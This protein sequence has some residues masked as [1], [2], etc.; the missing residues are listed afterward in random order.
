MERKQALSELLQ[1]IRI[2]ILDDDEQTGSSTR[3]RLMQ[4]DYPFV[5][6]TRDMGV[7]RQ[8]LEHTNILLIDHYLDNSE[9]N[10]IEFTREAKKKYGKNLD[11]IIYY[12]SVDKLAQ[13]AQ[14]AGATACLEKPLIFEYLLL[15]IE[16][17][18]KR[19]WLEKILDAIP[20]EVVVI[21]PSDEYFGR[22]HYVNK[23]KKEHFENNVPLEYDYCWRR[24]ERKGLGKEPCP[25]CI[26]RNAISSRRAVR[27]YR[28]YSTWDGK[29]EAVDIH[30]API[31]DQVGEIRGIIETCRLRTDREKVENKLKQIEAEPDWT[32]RLDLFLEGFVD[33]GYS[34]VRFYKCQKDSD[35][36]VGVKQLGMPKKF[37]IKNY[38]YS[39][40]EDMPTRITCS[41]KYPTLFL[42]KPNEGYK[43][44]PAR[45]YQHVY[46]VDDELVPNN[47]ILAKVKWVEIPVM[48]DG[49]IIAKVS[50]EPDLPD[51]FISNYELEILNDYSEWAGQALMNAEQSQRL[52][53]NDETKKLIIDMNRK[54]SRMSLRPAWMS[55]AVKRVCEVLD[56][57][58]CSIFLLEGEG[59]NQRLV[60]QTTYLCNIKGERI[61]RINL[62]E[63]YKIGQSFVGSVFERG[64]KK[65]YEDLETVAERQRKGGR[66]V[67]NLEAYDYYSQQIGEKVQNIMYVVLR[68]GNKKIGVIRTL[69]KRRMDIFGSREF[70][71]DDMAA[72]EALAGQISIGIETGLL[73]NEIKKSNEL[74]EFYTQEYSHTM[75]NL[76]QPIITISDLLQKDPSDQELWTLLEHEIIKMKTT[77][78]TMLHLVGVEDTNLKLNKKQV[79]VRELMQ[80]VIKPY[81]LVA[82]DKGLRINTVLKK[83]YLPVLLDETLIYDAV[84]NL[85][86]NAIKYGI[87]GTFINITSKIRNNELYI[88]V[89]DVGETITEHERKEIFKRFHTGKNVISKVHQMGLGLT[90]V[91]VVAEA[92]G[93]T[94][95]VDPSFT[96]G[97]KFVMK[98]PFREN[99]KEQS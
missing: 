12:G 10:G 29:E 47:R 1:Y 2:L 4:N 66:K 87:P 3:A 40:E 25:D 20:D 56:T 62:V 19:I 17:T 22:L 46:K 11:I 63:K 80:R 58:S 68:K 32:K 93:G 51:K 92:H 89:S 99:G 50:V 81:E 74:K 61:K 96:I 37:N 23:A 36:F 67:L 77:I 45:N 14:E 75:K 84:A 38:Q 54:I 7:A 69:N 13:A 76:M 85:L 15:W 26:S 94:I 79:D 41:E 59:D 60:R 71:E 88:S 8:E 97:A 27:T 5:I 82:A 57:S 42:V 39:I 64:R 86:D 90:F 9:M 73:L 28:S 49:E 24:F 21:D 18:A 83:P 31:R 98:L 55:L 95:D 43:W 91:K 35:V 6:F 72:F 44:A 48:A 65:I 33:L 70:T 30:A 16:E 53:L 78:N 52:R 34:R